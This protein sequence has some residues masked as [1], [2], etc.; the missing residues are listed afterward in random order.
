[1]TVTTYTEARRKFGDFCDQAVDDREPVLVRRRNGDDVVI[2]AADEYESI[3]ETAHLLASPRNAQRLR[4][5][6]A[7]ARQG[8]TQPMSVEELREAVGLWGAVPRG[9]GPLGQARQ[10]DSAEGTALG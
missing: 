2:L 8:D 7:S 4:Q 10:Q 3:S 1:M 9:L 6:L 5:A